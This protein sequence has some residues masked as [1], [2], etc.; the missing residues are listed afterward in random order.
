M[1]HL[2]RFNKLLSIQPVSKVLSAR[3]SFIDNPPKKGEV[4]DD[5]DSMKPPKGVSKYG[6]HM[7]RLYEDGP[8]PKFDANT[9]YKYWQDMGF[10]ERDREFDATAAHDTFFS[11]VT[12]FLC[13]SLIVLLYNPDTHQRDW[14]QREAYIRLAEREKLNLPPVDKYLIDPSR[15]ILPTDEEI[16]EYPIVV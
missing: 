13:G 3:V 11:A 8:P 7:P 6:D 1:S 10:D 12:I 4:D 15:I 5:P 16:G 9:V 2:L 14:A